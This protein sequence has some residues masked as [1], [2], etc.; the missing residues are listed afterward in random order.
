[1]NALRLADAYKPLDF[2]NITG[3]PH[4]M[5]ATTNKI[6]VFHGN[7]VI[8]A[9]EHWD[10]FMEYINDMGIDHLDLL[11]KCF[12]LSLK[13]DATKWFQSLPDHSIDSIEACKNVFFDKWMEKKDLRFL[14]RCF[15]R[16]DKI[17]QDILS[18]HQPSVSSSTN[19]TPRHSLLPK[20]TARQLKKCY[21]KGYLIL[22]KF[23][24]LCS[25]NTR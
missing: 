12:S 24:I 19:P 13:M 5:A 4:A 11:L 6:L 16:F 21:R 10:A 15:D 25:Q 1:M 17:V 2:S 18:T 9:R 23:R 14:F 8:G 22:C 20:S 3:Y 7:N